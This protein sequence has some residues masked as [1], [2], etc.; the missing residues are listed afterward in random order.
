M[1]I[2]EEEYNFGFIF[3]FRVLFSCFW[4]QL[5]FELSVVQIPRSSRKINLWG[6]SSETNKPSN[7]KRCCYLIDSSTFNASLFDRFWFNNNCLTNH[8][9]AGGGNKNI[10]L[11]NLKEWWSV[12]ANFKSQVQ[13]NTMEEPLF[14]KHV[15]IVSMP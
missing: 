6:F 2:V 3:V 11:P 9:N 1:S 14:P 10:C 7:Y 13:G 12:K 8:I 5:L 15:S 4:L